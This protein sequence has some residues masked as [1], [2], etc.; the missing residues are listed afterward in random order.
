MKGGRGKESRVE[1]S[2][3]KTR[4]WTKSASHQDTF[5]YVDPFITLL[6]FFAVSCIRNTGFCR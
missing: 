6:S 4:K 2:F 3:K 5:V 1:K